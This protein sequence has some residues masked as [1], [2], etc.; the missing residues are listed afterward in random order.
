MPNELLPNELL[1][2]ERI[3]D[4]YLGLANHYQDCRENKKLDLHDTYNQLY[5][6][7]YHSLNDAGASLSYLLPEEKMKAYTVLN[8]FF[9]ASPQFKTLPSPVSGT[10]FMYG[11][12]LQSTV[13][14]IDP[15][16]KYHC[17][18]NDFFLNMI[19]LN[20]LHRSSYSYF[21][22]RHRGSN[23]HTHD[24][25]AQ[26]K[27]NQAMAGLLLVA[28]VAA[29]AA[30]A[31]IA[32]FY[33][34]RQMLNS[35]E[36]FYYNEGW[37]QASLTMLSI[38]VSGI[39]MGMLANAFVL[40]PLLGL[41]IAAGV[42]NPVGLA[43]F[44]VIG[45]SIV[46]AA[47][48]CL[49][50]NSI[51]QQYIKNSNALSPTDPYRFTLTDAEAKNLLAK[52]I[53]PIKVKCALVALDNHISKLPESSM[54]AR[55]FSIRNSELSECLDKVRDLR[56]G[57]FSSRALFARQGVMKVGRMEFDC[58]LAPT[59]RAV[60]VALPASAFAV[61]TRHTHTSA[62]FASEKYPGTA[63]YAGDSTSRRVPSNGK[64][65][66]RVPE[67]LDADDDD[68]SAPALGGSTQYAPSAPP[69]FV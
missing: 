16:P 41:A 48:G 5:Y 52:G 20:S 53:D 22:Y 18:H 26:D 44:G 66:A 38:A 10:F 13:V 8:T 19:L 9:Y 67:A 3:R 15:A 2:D 27:K 40:S 65:L 1:T 62:M 6:H 12:A 21:A 56:S 31:F 68:P 59:L 51:Q 23:I 57:N 37:M 7:L 46:G 11:E 39:A 47:L 29:I 50:S 17:Q 30:S 49:I 61:A 64:L 55:L 14:I 69:A 63:G 25:S 36:R 60:P 58:T 24:Q 54:C 28:V 4:L 43:V 42:A 32:L 45:I 35:A 33:L 34:V